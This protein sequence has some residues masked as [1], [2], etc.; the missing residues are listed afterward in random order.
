KGGASI[1]HPSARCNGP[2]NACFSQIRQEFQR[3]RK[4][5][6]LFYEAAIGFSVELLNVCDFFRGHLTSRL[7]QQSVHQQA[8]THAD[9]A[10]DTPHGNPNAPAL[11]CLPPRQ[12]VL[13]DTVDESAIEVEQKRRRRRIAVL[14]RIF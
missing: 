10:M 13:V 6:H 2:S 12:N 8:A 4:D 5:T 7:P 1:L 11:K 3:A 9:S 14:R